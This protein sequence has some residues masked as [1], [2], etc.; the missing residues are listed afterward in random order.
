MMKCK[1]YHS[2]AFVCLDEDHKYRYGYC[3]D[4]GGKKFIKKNMRAPKLIAPYDNIRKENK[5]KKSGRICRWCGVRLPQGRSAWC[6][7]ECNHKYLLQI[8]WGELKKHVYLRDK[9]CCVDCGIEVD[10]TY[11]LNYVLHR[12]MYEPEDRNRKP[13]FLNNYNPRKKI[14]RPMSEAHHIHPLDSGGEMWDQNNIVTLCH[15]CH[16]KRHAELRKGVQHEAYQNTKCFSGSGSQ[17]GERN[18]IFSEECVA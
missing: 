7:D 13:D 6:S 4:C 9:G 5:G 17:D 14:V 2:T 1:C 15:A 11:N 18:S 16:L 3:K 10:Y 8:N 12:E